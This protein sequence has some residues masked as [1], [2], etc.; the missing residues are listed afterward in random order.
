[1]LHE[2]VSQLGVL[3]RGNRFIF[4]KDHSGYCA[5]NRSHRVRDKDGDKN[6]RQEATATIRGEVTGSL[7]RRWWEQ[8]RWKGV[9]SLG[10]VF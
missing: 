1:M 8:W 9:V 2:V 3:S 4:L 6:T 7:T 10:T 5:E